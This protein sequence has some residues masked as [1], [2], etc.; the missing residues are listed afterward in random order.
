[1]KTAREGFNGYFEGWKRKYFISGIF[2]LTGMLISLADF[3]L[4]PDDKML[5]LHILSLGIISLIICLVFYIRGKYE[6]LI[7]TATDFLY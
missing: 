2:F 4:L 1:M 7:E 3:F 6:K 5:G